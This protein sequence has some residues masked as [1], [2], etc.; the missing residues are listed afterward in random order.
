MQTYIRNRA[1]HCVRCRAKGLAGA[2]FLIT[3]GVLFLLDNLSVL[4]FDHSWP[5]LMIVAGL[6]MIASR[7]ASIEGHVQPWEV[8]GATQQSESQVQP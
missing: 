6:C 4:Y 8:R 5:I 2:A 1:C 7:N 3:L